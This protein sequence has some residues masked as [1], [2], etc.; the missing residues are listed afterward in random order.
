MPTP[1]TLPTLDDWLAIHMPAL[2]TLR[3]RDVP[4]LVASAW[5]H[6]NAAGHAAGRDAAITQALA[7]VRARNAEGNCSGADL[8]RF[9]EAQLPKVFP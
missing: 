1:Y 6:G 3:R 4:P 9:M 8:L 7:L 2:V 5:N